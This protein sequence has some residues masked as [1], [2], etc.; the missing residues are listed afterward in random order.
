MRIWDVD[1]SYL[2]RKQLLAEHCELHGLYNTVTL[3]RTRF[4]NHPETLG[5]KTE[6]NDIRF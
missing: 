2:D 5:W 4:G 1:P 3:K 6:M